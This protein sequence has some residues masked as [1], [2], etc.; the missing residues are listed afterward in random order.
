MGFNSKEI[1]VEPTTKKSSKP[2]DVDYISKMGYRDDSPFRNRASIDIH[3]P[4]GI[5]D[6]SNTGIPL[7]ANGAFLPP[8]SGQHQF[9]TNIVTE[10]R[11]SE[12]EEMRYGGLKKRRTTT[13]PA[14]G[15]NDLMLRNPHYH[16]AKGKHFVPFKKQGGTMNKDDSFYVPY[17]DADRLRAT[18]PINFV[19]TPFYQEGGNWGG[20]YRNPQYIIDKPGALKKAGSAARTSKD[21]KVVPEKNPMRK[22]AE[23][24]NDE[25]VNFARNRMADASQPY[26][27]RKT[28]EGYD[29]LSA[30]DRDKITNLMKTEAFTNLMQEDFERRKKQ[31]WF[32]TYPERKARTEVVYN[33]GG[34]SDGPLGYFGDGGGRKKGNVEPVNPNYAADSMATVNYAALHPELFDPNVV[35]FGVTGQGKVQ[36]FPMKNGVQGRP[37]PIASKMVPTAERNVYQTVITDPKY[38]GAENEKALKWSMNELEKNNSGEG[39]YQPFPGLF[40]VAPQQKFG[41]DNPSPMNY[42]AFPVMMGGGEFTMIIND[43]LKKQFGGNGAEEQSPSI[44]NVLESKRNFFNNYIRGNVSKSFAD[45]MHNE[46]QQ[47]MMGQ[48]YRQQGGSFNDVDANTVTGNNENLSMQMQDGGGTNDEYSFMNDVNNNNNDNQ[49]FGPPYE[50][51]QRINTGP[52]MQ[53]FPMITNQDLQN[54]NE[55][56]VRTNQENQMNDRFM[57]QPKKNYWWNGV[58][59][60]N[61]TIAQMQGLSNLLESSQNAKQAEENKKYES[62]DYVF[63]AK[64][65]G[66]SSRGDYDPNSGDFRKNQYTPVQFP[67]FNMGNA[68][69]N[70]YAQMGGG[71]KENDDV[72]MSDEE[73]QQ[74]LAAGGEIEF[75]D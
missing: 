31:G 20:T 21:V 61:G 22:D 23:L 35:Q 12:D 69:T 11:M 5:I 67:G 65:E 51:Q 55:M 45:E 73:I 40:G 32:E 28:M 25:I 71:F 59:V 36:K 3:T 26:N 18:T 1:K 70:E 74:Y 44:D 50:Q 39:G 72:Y 13:N 68:G 41:G 49:K 15:I 19:N 9:D 48:S 53:T 56:Q 38:A 8:Y 17:Q 27:F 6:M 57:K 42:G 60:A 62:G 14:V 63:Q 54:R 66:S 4:N 64:P 30:T 16:T 75:L 43:L 52:E 2:K 37:Q 10:S 7:M 58:D 46:M 34:A 29:L 33:F 47:M 24:S